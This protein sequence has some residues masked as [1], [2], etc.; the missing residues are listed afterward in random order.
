MIEKIYDFSTQDNKKIE[1]TID[2]ENLVINHMILPMNESLPE[3]YSNANVYMIIA[4]GTMSL[5]LNEQEPHRYAHGEI[6]NIPYN[7]KMNVANADENILEFF[8]V[9]TPNPKNYIGDKQ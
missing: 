4:R 3:H 5:K 2:D 8:V 1:K 7:T 6:I 9:K